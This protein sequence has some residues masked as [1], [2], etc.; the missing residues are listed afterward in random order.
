VADGAVLLSLSKFNKVEVIESKSF[1]KTVNV[2]GGCIWA[3][4]ALDL[5]NSSL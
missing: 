4:V 2:G 1:S 3:E 5:L